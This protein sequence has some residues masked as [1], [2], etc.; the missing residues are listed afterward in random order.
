MMAFVMLIAPTAVTAQAA[1][2]ISLGQS[3]SGVLEEHDPTKADRPYDDF[4][5]TAVPGTEARAIVRS[6]TMTVD[7]NVYFYDEYFDL[8]SLVTGGPEA[9]DTV[10]FTVPNAG[11]PTV[12]V[13]RVTTLAGDSGPAFGEYT[14]ELSERQIP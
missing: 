4:Q 10:E 11:S 3:L 5:Y 2:E 7:V 1:P 12:I 14:I 6:P 9:E 8:L 13:L